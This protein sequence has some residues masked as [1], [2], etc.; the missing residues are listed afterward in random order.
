M[1]TPILLTSHGRSS[2]NFGFPLLCS[3]PPLIQTILNWYFGGTGSTRR[4][5]APVAQNCLIRRSVRCHS[6][7]RLKNVGAC[8][9]SKTT[10]QLA[11]TSRGCDW[12]IPYALGWLKR[13]LGP[14]AY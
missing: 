13:P 9:C 1:L 12:S 8:A 2:S 10:L 6:R 3:Y 5:T 11:P 14:A 7:P 4:L